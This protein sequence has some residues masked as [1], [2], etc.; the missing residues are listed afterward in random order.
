MLLLR[1]IVLSIILI[2]AT[3]TDFKRREIDHEPIIIGFVFII[4]FSLCDF[5][6]VSVK[7]SILG[8][9][10]G[11]VVFTI[12]AFWGMGGGDIKLMA[13]IGFFLGW[14]LTILT[15]YISFVLGAIIGILYMIFKK[16]KLKEHI[17]FAPAIAGATFVVMF[18][19]IQIINNCKYLWFLR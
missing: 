4:L 14:E 7:N 13:L 1:N 2:V 12:L 10:I 18:F 8:F 19:G 15:M 5:N 17:P 9:L 6:N 16:V 11:G 3:Y